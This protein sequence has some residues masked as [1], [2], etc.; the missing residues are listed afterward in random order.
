MLSVNSIT[1]V[2]ISVKSDCFGMWR[3]CRTRA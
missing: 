2:V 1:F 3:M